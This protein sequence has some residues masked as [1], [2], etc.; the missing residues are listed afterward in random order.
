MDHVAYR[1]DM[2]YS[3][4]TAVGKELAA[5]GRAVILPSDKPTTPESE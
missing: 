2:K 4:L 5:N 1:M 3:T